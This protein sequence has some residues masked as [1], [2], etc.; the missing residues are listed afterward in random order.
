MTAERDKVTNERDK[1][2][3]DSVKISLLRTSSITV[4]VI[5]D[6]LLSVIDWVELTPLPFGPTSV[7]GVVS[8]QGR[9]FTVV[10][11]ETI[12]GVSTERHETSMIAAL[13]GDEQL[14]IAVEGTSDVVEINLGDVNPEPESTLIRGK[15]QVN[16]LDVLL[17]DLDALFA[18]VIRGRERRRRRL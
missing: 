10:D 5:E 15:V 13:R 9:M 7:F 17:L 6:Q 2:T 11:I 3:N 4:G 1:V 12:L 14:A 18:G 8:V 16:N